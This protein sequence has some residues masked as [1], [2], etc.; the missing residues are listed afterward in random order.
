LHRFYKSSGRLDSFRWC[1]HGDLVL[2]PGAVIRP[3]LDFV[4]ASQK[5]H[6]IVADPR[7]VAGKVRKLGANTAVGLANA[8]GALVD[9]GLR[10]LKSGEVRLT[11]RHS[12]G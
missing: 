10:R 1:D 6:V 5:H 4:T 11:A 2:R 12:R 9:Q 3:R 8:P 7:F